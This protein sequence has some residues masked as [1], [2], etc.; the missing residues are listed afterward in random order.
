M[1]E[2]GRRL[3][4]ACAV[5]TAAAALMP[6]AHAQGYPRQPIRLIVPFAP[7]G[8]VDQTARIIGNTLGEK[9]GQTMVIDN[10]PG[11]SGSLGAGDL[12]RA[13]PD[14]Y[15][16]MLALDSQ[17]VNHLTVKNL[18]FDTFK[19][20]DYLSL[21]VTTP[22]VLVTRND[23]PV[24]NL[25]ELVAYL[26]ANPKSSYGSAGTA[27]AG[28]VNSAQLSLAKGL[29]TEH[30]PYKGAGPLLTDMLGGHIDYA[31]AGLSVM[32]PQIKAGKVRALAVSSP[33]RSAMLPDVPAMNELIPGFEYPTW[34]G[35]VAP[36]GMPPD[37]RQKIL[38]AVREAMHD[39]QVAR[40]FGEN[41][42]DIVNGTPE[43][44]TER[45]RKDAEVM[46]DLVKRGI[47]TGG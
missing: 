1:L 5:A 18:P 9:L 23:L 3:L 11:A 10:K 41:A 33:G 34:I 12:H 45:V 42:Y 43:Q 36:P 8:A 15:T 25:D 4:L 17:A 32:L 14:G 31:F 22:Q 28:H 40:R 39:P 37:V 35:I 20:F 47:V 26:K 30:V 44:F 2:T 38:K 24:K 46:N 29:R 13:K 7:G 19:D 21:L 16:L 27:S 6:A